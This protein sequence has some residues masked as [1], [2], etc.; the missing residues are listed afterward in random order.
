MQCRMNVA[1]LKIS[2]NMND[3]IH[4]KEVQEIR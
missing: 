4:K 2:K 1:K 3:N